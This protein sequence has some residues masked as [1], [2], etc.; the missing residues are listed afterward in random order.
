MSLLCLPLSSFRRHFAFLSLQR[1]NFDKMGVSCIFRPSAR[2]LAKGIEVPIWRALGRW[3]FR[4]PKCGREVVLTT[5]GE[6]IYNF[7]P[8]SR[9]I[10]RPLL[11]S[12]RTRSG[13]LMIS[14]VLR[15][16]LASRRLSSRS[17]ARRTKSVRSSSSSRMRSM[18]ANVPALIGPWTSSTARWPPKGRLVNHDERRPCRQASRDPVSDSGPIL[19]HRSGP[20]SQLSGPIAGFLAC[21]EDAQGIRL[22][23]APFH[24]RGPTGLH[25]TQIAK[26]KKPKQKKCER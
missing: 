15:S 18:R 6:P 21:V 26:M 3:T 20:S 4:K 5:G 22:P 11:S 14:S 23:S 13:A 25:R 1:P 9:K 24:R 16:F 8:P 19:K 12:Y 17:A 10:S 7:E 2:T